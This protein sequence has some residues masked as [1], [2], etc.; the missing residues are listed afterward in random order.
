MYYINEYGSLNE[1]LGEGWHVRVTNRIGDFSYVT[2]KTVSFHLLKRNPIL[3]YETKKKEDG[4]IIL[5]PSYIAQPDCIVFSFVRG[6]G[7][8][9]E[10]V[11]F[12]IV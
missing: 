5:E 3:D 2:L 9:K 11:N 8:R 10:L 4:T 1:L 6:D 7:N 12:Q